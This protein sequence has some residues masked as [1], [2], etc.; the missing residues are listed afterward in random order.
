MIINGTSSCIQAKDIIDSMIESGDVDGAI[1][2]VDSLSSSTDQV[3]NLKNLRAWTYAEIGHRTRQV[4]LI[5]TG[6]ELWTSIANVN[7]SMISYNIASST[8]DVWSLHVSRNNLSDSW[9]KQRHTLHQARKLLLE[10]VQNEQ[11]DTEHRLKALVDAGN[12][13]DIVGR[14]FDALD[15]YN[16]ALRIDPTFGMARGNRGLALLYAAPLMGSYTDDVLLQS[17]RDLDA[18][19]ENSESVLRH[20]GESALEQFKRKRSTIQSRAGGSDDLVREPIDLG[21]SYLNWC[22]YNNLFLDASPDHVKTNSGTLDPVFFRQITTGLTAEEISQTNELIDAFNA[23]KQDYI[24]ARYLL[25]LAVS[26]ESLIRDHSQLVARRTSFLDTLNYAR[27][28]VR[29]GLGHLALRA[30]VDILDK[31]ASFVHLYFSSGRS[32]NVT[33]PS[34]PY[35]GPRTSDIAQPFVD[36]LRSPEGNRG[37]MALMDLSCDAESHSSSLSINV[38]R[39]HAGTHRFLVAHTEMP[40]AGSTWTEHVNWSDVIHGALGQLGAA[41]RGVLYLAQMIDID[42]ELKYGPESSRLSH[43]PL[44]YWR[45]DTDLMECE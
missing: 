43:M 23:V 37:L 35:S 18:A 45:S 3:T 19:I 11:T 40:P 20:G 42:D 38:Q 1:A 44:P 7:S 34:L 27:W 8:F 39:R 28:G 15:C 6:I 16:S 25:W 36:A 17:A 22:L 2:F 30:S 5:E 31:I 9:M 14:N 12:S 4:D 21:D 32:R 26:D 13:Y 29:T 41:R 24:S 10:T 33:F